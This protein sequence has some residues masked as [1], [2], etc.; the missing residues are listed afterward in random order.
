[1][2]RNENMAPCNRRSR[3]DNK[4]CKSRHDRPPVCAS[5]M[6]RCASPKSIKRGCWRIWAAGSSVETW[7]DL[8]GARDPQLSL[9]ACLS[10]SDPRV[11]DDG[12]RPTTEMRWVESRVRQQADYNTS[13]RLAA[14][15]QG[16]HT[17][18]N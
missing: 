5:W 17:P 14:G 8:P 2:V 7:D 11:L 13:P 15:M 4:A 18:V 10:W 3:S 16:M 12:S 1:M 6:V 9:A